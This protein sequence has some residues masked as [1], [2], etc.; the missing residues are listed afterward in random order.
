MKTF[1]EFLVK[2]KYKKQLKDS[3]NRF[4]KDFRK[5]TYWESVEKDFIKFKKKNIRSF[6]KVFKHDIFND[7]VLDDEGKIKALASLHG[8]KIVDEKIS[9]L[10][11]EYFFELEKNLI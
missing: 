6:S 4:K 2:E 8:Y 7:F 3:F 10:E 1:E 5:I 11:T 9:S